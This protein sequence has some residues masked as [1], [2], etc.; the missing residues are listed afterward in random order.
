MADWAA[1]NQVDE[2]PNVTFIP[3]QAYFSSYEMIQRSK[4]V[5]IYNSTIGMEAAIMGAPVLSA[6][7]ARF[8]QLDTVFFPK[9]PDAYLAKLE[10][11]LTAD[12]VEAHQSIK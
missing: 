3:P 2:L 1:K 4:F 7:K 10:A 9:T 5:M 12:K 6:G 11:F 8:S